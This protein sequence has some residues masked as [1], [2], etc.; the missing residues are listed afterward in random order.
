MN[1]KTSQDFTTAG[2]AVLSA[3]VLSCCATK[4]ESRQPPP[5]VVVA[6]SKPKAKSHSKKKKKPLPEY[7]GEASMS[8]NGTITLNLGVYD[9]D[10]N[11]VG[12]AQQVYQVGDKDYRE[13]LEHLGGMK[14]GEDKGVKPWPEKD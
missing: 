13:V 7:I 14:P 8:R 6:D 2:L 5:D 9:D 12:L 3:V 4:T 10:A 1:T 11:A